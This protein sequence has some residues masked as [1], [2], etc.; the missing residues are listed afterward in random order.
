MGTVTIECKGA[1]K[2]MVLAA[3]AR[4]ANASPWEEVDD[5][6]RRSDIELL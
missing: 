6:L 3:A 4:P 2:L 1:V 5:N